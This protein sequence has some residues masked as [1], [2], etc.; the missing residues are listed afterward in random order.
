MKLTTVAENWLERIALW[1]KLA[2][3]PLSDTHLAFM[4]ARTVMVATKAGIFEALADQAQ[5]AE[6]IAAQCSTDTKAT[7]TLLNTLVHLGYV[8]FKHHQ[9]RLAP[10]AR[11]WMLKNSASSLHDKMLL[12]F[13]EWEFV[14]H[15]ETYVRTGQPFEMHEQLRED[16]WPVYQ[17]GMRS[18]AGISSSEVAR[19]TPVPKGAT[20]MLDIGG[21][22]GHYSTALCH[23]HPAL[24]AVILELPEAIRHSKAILAKEQMGERV[25][26]RAG[27]AL[28]DDLGEAEWDVVFISSLL[29]HF[30]DTTNAALSQRVFR[31]LRPGGLYIVQEY[32]RSDEPKAGDHLGGLLDLYFAATSKAGTYSEAE[33]KRWQREAGFNLQRSV[34]LRSIPRHAQIIAKKP[35]S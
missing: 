29:H 25:T 26:Y 7:Q 3:L 5:T 24:Q 1:L 4:L 19:R 20:R 28:T 30:D 32:M 16:Q 33:I 34:W 15:Y 13:L 12:Q 10:L 11:K 14:E 17:R 2:P 9:Y 6:H 18:V 22:H 23:Q 35:H 27:N 31:A 8:R 21:A